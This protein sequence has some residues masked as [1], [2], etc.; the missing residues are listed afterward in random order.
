M[1][2]NHNRANYPTSLATQSFVMTDDNIRQ[3]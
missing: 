3:G 2:I 1:K